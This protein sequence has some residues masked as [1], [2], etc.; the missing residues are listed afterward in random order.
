MTPTPTTMQGS[1]FATCALPGCGNPVAGWGD[2]CADC[3][4]AFSGYLQLAAEDQ[5]ALTEHDLAERDRAV[6][7]AQAG[8]RVIAAGSTN[9]HVATADGPL[10]RRNQRCWLCE[11]RRTCSQMPQG[12]ECDDCRDVR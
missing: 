3:V 11:S 7:D 9:V 6:A 1:L 2:I 5:P 4:A 12:W 10:R 8:Q